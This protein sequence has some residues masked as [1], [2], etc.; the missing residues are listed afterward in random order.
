MEFSQSVLTVCGA[1]V[2][3]ALAIRIII[4]CVQFLKW[5]FFMWATERASR[6]AHK[7]EEVENMEGRQ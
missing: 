3:L 7:K 4:S 1:I 6:K 5:Q 2:T